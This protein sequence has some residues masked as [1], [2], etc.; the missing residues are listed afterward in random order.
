[1][2]IVMTAVPLLLLIVAGLTLGIVLVLAK[3]SQ[4]LKQQGEIHKK[5]VEAEKSR[6]VA[7]R[8]RRLCPAGV[9][10]MYT[11]VAQDW[12]SKQTK[13]QPLQRDLLQKASALLPG[14]RR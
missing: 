5:K 7:R 6:E 1:M 11:L 3:Q 4:I 9:D 12:L 14:V 10:E 2:A 13:L 8:Q